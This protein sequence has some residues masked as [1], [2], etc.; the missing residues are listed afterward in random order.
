MSRTRAQG[1]KAGAEQGRVNE[2]QKPI[3]IPGV[4][5]G[6]PGR[7]G[8][9]AGDP[10]E[11][12]ELQ[13]LVERVV[14]GV[15]HRGHPPGEVGA[16]PDPSERG[17]GV[18]VGERRVVL[19]QPGHERR[20]EQRDVGDREVEPLGAG[21]RDDVRGVAGEEQPAVP[22]RR[23][24]E[25]A[26]RQHR[27]VGDR[28]GLQR[29]AVLTVAEPRGEPVPDPV[30][31]PVVERR[32]VRHLEV[33]PRHRRRPHR[34][35]REAVRVPGVDQLVGRRRDVGEDAEPGVRVGPLPRPRRPVRR[36]AMARTSRRSRPR[37]RRA[38]APP[39]RPR[40]KVTDGSSVSRSCRAVSAT[41]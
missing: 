9:A 32:V 27:P 3:G 11:L 13:L 28:A 26:H 8:L 33:E 17:V 39:H 40:V 20:G 16:A 14:R 10:A 31:G 21:R 35:Q 7:A 5:L 30:V 15:Q 4:V 12:R 22:H 36:R 6:Q 25:R 38:A 1:E 24:D 41:S 18:R 2:G 23:L 34:V 37:R 19:A 29:P